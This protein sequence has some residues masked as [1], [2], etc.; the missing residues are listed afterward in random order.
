[1]L[2]VI[3]LHSFGE[4]IGIEIIRIFDRFSIFITT[5]SFS[6]WMLKYNKKWKSTNSI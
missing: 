3:V 4:F 1:M 2:F 6:Y 5:R